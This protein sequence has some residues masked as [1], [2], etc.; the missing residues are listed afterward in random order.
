MLKAFSLSQQNRIIVTA[1]VKETFS[2]PP[3]VWSHL[4][5]INTGNTATDDVTRRYAAVVRSWNAAAADCT[6][7]IYR[8][9]IP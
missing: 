8:T 1:R 6:V 3:A 9:G 2:W 5:Y 7:P 4:V